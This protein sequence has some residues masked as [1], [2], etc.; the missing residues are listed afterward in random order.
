MYIYELSQAIYLSAR[1]LALHLPTS[2][3]PTPFR[4]YLHYQ[5]TPEPEMLM[6]DLCHNVPPVSI[7]IK[8][9]GGFPTSFDYLNQLQSIF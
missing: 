1:T 5:V 9:I 8:L 2:L 7:L 4:P 3:F 6:R